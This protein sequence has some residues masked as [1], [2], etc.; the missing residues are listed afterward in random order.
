MKKMI[1][2]LIIMM[3]FPVFNSFA[4]ESEIEYF[5]LFLNGNRSGYAVLSRQV[6]GNKVI[7]SEKTYFELNRMG[8][9]VTID[10]TDTSI[11]T[12]EGKPLG[13]KTK[14]KMAMMSMTEEGEIFPDGTMKIISTNAGNKVE[15]SGVYPKGAL[16]VEGMDLLVK[17]HGLKSGTTFSAD[18]FSPSIKDAIKMTYTVGDK[19]QTDLLGRVVELIEIKGEYTMPGA[20]KMLTTEYVDE[21][22]KAQKMIVPIAGMNIEMIACP[23]SYAMSKL[24]PMEM[25]SSMILESPK[26]IQGLK[27]IKEIIYTVKA[28]NP[29]TELRFP[30]TDSQKVRAMNNGSY[31]ITVSKIPGNRSVK[32]PYNG[33][34]PLILESLEETSYLQIKHPD[35]VSL[36]KK[37]VEGKNSALDAALAIESFVSGYIESK[38]LSVGYASALEVLKSRQGDC[39]EHAILTAALCRAAG[40][41]A[42]MA[43]GLVYAESFIGK[44]NIFG[45]HAWT[46]VYIGDKWIGLDA[47]IKGIGRDCDA[48]RITL[49]VGNG[50]QG[51]FFNALSTLGNFT[52]Q[53][54]KTSM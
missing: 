20:G 50:D 31:Q 14:Q 6:E 38:N 48:G 54:I 2:M 53:D 26:S 25:V 18:M 36:A 43:T 9:S 30:S 3:S 41:P 16:M 37:C 23:E 51:G 29:E 10:S 1:I 11:E 12:V 5:A 32:F 44:E 49:A 27:D 22:Y 39:T 42:R 46:E 52:I 4:A 24:E 7:T 8:T 33:N 28:K 17:K 47:A 19:K 40:I 34:D 13:F 21:N 35:I 15:S 45:G